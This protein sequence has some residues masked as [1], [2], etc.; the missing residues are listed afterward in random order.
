MNLN[1]NDNIKKEI[2][3]T[4]NEKKVLD[5]KLSLAK[6]QFIDEIK[7]NLGEEIKKNGN[8]VEVIK[9]TFWEKIRKIIK[10]IFTRF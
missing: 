5:A 8:K 10:K 9:P 4:K 6:N 1:L 7:Y 2:D 3:K